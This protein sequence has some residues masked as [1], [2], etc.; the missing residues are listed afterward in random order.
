MVAEGMHRE[1]VPEDLSH[2]HFQRELDHSVEGKHNHD[3]TMK[4]KHESS[5]YHGLQH[6]GSI[7]KARAP[8]ASVHPK[9]PSYE[10]HTITHTT[11][12]GQAHDPREDEPLILDVGPG[13]PEEGL[14]H[15]ISE[16]PTGTDVNVYEEAYRQEVERIKRT[17]GRSATVYLTRRVENQSE[18]GR[19]DNNKDLNENGGRPKIKWGN[20]LEMAKNRAQS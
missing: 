5:S 20:I 7:G 6:E 19:D 17:K 12:K 14:P 1:V 10:R 11:G 13:L 15:V 18:V 8:P 4:E 2:D 9:H 3:L 16:S